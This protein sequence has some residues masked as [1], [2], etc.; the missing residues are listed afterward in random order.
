M[1]LAPAQLANLSR[2]RIAA[3]AAGCPF[4]GAAAAESAVESAWYTSQS[5]TAHNNILGIRQPSW[6]TGPT[7]TLAT[8]EQRPDGT[9]YV[10]PNAVWA[11][12]DSWA[13]CFRC[14]VEIFQRNP[15]YA[16]LA[17]ITTAE[18]Y[19]SAESRIWSTGLDRGRLVMAVY[20][21]HLDI[22]LDKARVL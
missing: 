17:K 4:P 21:A 8:K 7:F 1:S 9:W 15:A 2:A 6:R 11:A 22:L 18:E 10:D 19:I 16:E 13:D 5:C 14:Q 3:L 12:F 20:H